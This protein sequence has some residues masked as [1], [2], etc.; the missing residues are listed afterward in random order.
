MTSHVIPAEGA[1]ELSAEVRN[2]AQAAG[3]HLMHEPSAAALCR[4]AADLKAVG[5]IRPNLPDGLKGSLEHA[6]AAHRLAGLLTLI[7]S[8]Q[9]KLAGLALEIV[10]QAFEPGSGVIELSAIKL[11]GGRVSVR[12][13]VG[14]PSARSKALAFLVEHMGWGNLYVGLQPRR[15]DWTGN[16]V[17]NE[18]DVLEYRRVGFDF[19][20][21]AGETDAD[22]NERSTK[23]VANCKSAGAFLVVMSGG[24]VQAFWKVT[25]SR[26]TSEIRG[27][28]SVVAALSKA[29]SSDNV[30]DLHRLMRLPFTVNLPTAKKLERGR[31]IALA[32]PVHFEPTAP[33]REFDETIR[34][35]ARAFGV[36]CPIDIGDPHEAAF[37]ELAESPAGSRVKS[38]S[39]SGHPVGEVPDPQELLAP[40]PDL[41]IRALRVIPNPPGGP[42]ADR[43]DWINLGL[44]FK[45]AVG[46]HPDAETVFVEWSDKFGGDPAEASRAFLSFEPTQLGW[47]RLKKLLREHAAPEVARSIIGEAAFDY[48]FDG[49]DDPDVDS[50]L[51]NGAGKKLS[52]ARSAIKR[53][54][55]DGMR[56]IQSP[57]GRSF[58]RIDARTYAIKSEAGKR[59]ITGALVSRNIM[60][61]KTQAG[62][63]FHELEARATNAQ[64]EKV[65]V[66]VAFE[67]G[68]CCLFF[69][70]GE[71][72]GRLIEVDLRAKAYRIVDGANGP[73]FIRPGTMAPLPDPKPTSTAGVTWIDN[74]A[75]HLNLPPIKV[76]GDPNDAGVQARAA[77]ILALCSWIMPIGTCAAVFINGPNGS[78]KTSAAR[79]L[80][81]FLD[82]TAGNVGR[83]GTEDRDL[84]VVARTRLALVLDNMSSLKG[85]YADTLCS[86]LS[87]ADLSRRALY[88]DDD[89]VSLPARAGLVLTSIVEGLIERPDLLDRAVTLALEPPL[90]RRS[91]AALA[92]EWDNDHPAMLHG[93]LLALAQGLGGREAIEATW[94]GRYAIRLLDAAT[95]AEAV[96]RASGWRDDL[97][98]EALNASKRST[99]EKMLENDPVASGIMALLEKS[100]PWIGTMSQLMSELGF[101]PGSHN[102]V[103]PLHPRGMRS[104]LDRLVTP[105]RS[106]TIEMEFEKIKAKSRDR[107]VTISKK[108]KPS[109]ASATV[110]SQDTEKTDV[111]TVRTVEASVF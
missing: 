71:E 15:S 16:R 70:L 51:S 73:A 72:T 28:K 81:G 62:D 85:D 83:P 30:G 64:R 25:P 35:I 3:E 65:H 42:F 47:P 10:T 96:A 2:A 52:A 66:R 111:R 80:T 22:W 110:Q 90:V 27:R 105:L 101:G 103:G 106:E 43:A 9:S 95:L 91:E 21:G 100:N 56:L 32:R 84:F 7:K 68:R 82:P 108:R 55:S 45:G 87:G 23:I 58:A 89:A 14:D 88:S 38:S 37:G 29:V 74:L 6:D 18:Q 109:D 53:L 20:R 67:Q 69:D 34:G 98:I 59:A 33:E 79:R 13:D 107:L 4:F 61:N 1:P 48:A 46:D 78:G 40:T 104:A 76:A 60:L 24:G 44:A 26:D 99:T 93:F 19:D 39:A 57:D 17:P 54:L 75:M 92:Q 97:L 50:D 11:H 5:A 49:G 94:N 41:A 63:F 12:L 36:E 86:L 31:E 8:S 102:K 77:V